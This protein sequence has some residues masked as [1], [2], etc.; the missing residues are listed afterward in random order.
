MTS[1]S[2]EFREFLYKFYV[3]Y[4]DLMPHGLYLAGESYAGKYL[5]LYIHDMLEHNKVNKDFQFPIKGL[6]IGDP[7]PSP[8]LQRTSMH[9]VA[10]GLN[11]LSDYQLDQLS[12]FYQTCEATISFNV[13]M[14]ADACDEAINYFELVS[15]KVFSYD[16]RIFT[17]DYE[18][19]Q[20][21]SDFLVNAN[22]VSAVYSALHATKFDPHSKNVS[23]QFK[24]D[25]ML[26][27]SKYYDYLIFNRFPT[28][29]IGGEYD[30]RDGAKGLQLWMKTVLTKLRPSFF[31]RE[32]LIYHFINNGETKVGGYYK[33]QDRFTY[34]TLPKSGHMFTYFN[35]N[36]TAAQLADFTMYQSLNCTDCST[37]DKKCEAMNNC[38]GNG[39]CAR[40]SGVCQCSGSWKGADCSYL[41]FDV[42]NEPK[43]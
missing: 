42:T 13:T 9:Y 1:A 25:F 10:Q 43:K 17:D 39:I 33:Q 15:G 7:F 40:A 31:E 29:L 8:L 28:L 41:A 36:A 37:V 38:N 16:A 14:A 21:W 4:S 6:F 5:P 23:E 24:P 11:I 12:V 27:Y 22:N 3:M 19:Y 26:D 2:E 20:Y 18:P 34:L 32:Q 30:N 35:Y